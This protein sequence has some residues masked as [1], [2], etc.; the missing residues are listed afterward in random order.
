MP[1]KSMPVALQVRKKIIGTFIWLQILHFLFF[2]FN[3]FRIRDK[4]ERCQQGLWKAC[5]NDRGRLHSWKKLFRRFLWHKKA[6]PETIKNPKSEKRQRLWKISGW[7]SQDSGL[8]IRIK[9]TFLP[10]ELSN[11]KL[12][13]G[14]GSELPG[15]E[16][17]QGLFIRCWRGKGEGDS[18]I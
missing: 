6:K 7:K 4:L 16:G 2:L 18:N 1:G 11:S 3:V 10:L 17:I 12:D 14:V 15:P 8:Y 5:K 13:F 9:M